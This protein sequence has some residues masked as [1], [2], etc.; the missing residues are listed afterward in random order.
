MKTREYLKCSCL[1]NLYAICCRIFLQP[2]LKMDADIGKAVGGI[3]LLNNSPSNLKIQIGDMWL[4]PSYKV[5]S[6]HDTLLIEAIY[7]L[8]GNLFCQRYRRV[9][10][11]VDVDDPSRG[12]ATSKL[13]FQ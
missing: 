7:L 2:L 9:E 5:G 10:W 1:F 4:H 8:L 6:N 11:L 3:S 13:G 12:F